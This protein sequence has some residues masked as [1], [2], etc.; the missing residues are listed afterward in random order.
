MLSWWYRNKFY[1]TY[2]ITKDEIHIIIS[3]F[4]EYGSC[5]SIVCEICLGK[6]TYTGPRTINMENSTPI[7]VPVLKN[8]KTFYYKRYYFNII[9][10]IFTGEIINY[11]TIKA[12]CGPRIIDPGIFNFVLKGIKNHYIFVINIWLHL[13]QEKV[14]DSEK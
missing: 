13:E 9:P 6:N 14:L 1:N 10:Q 8:Y 7:Q 12:S 3:D 4:G 2:Y 5:G 11:I